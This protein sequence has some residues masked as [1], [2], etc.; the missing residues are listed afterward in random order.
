[1][2]LSISPNKGPLT[3]TFISSAAC[4]NEWMVHL[5]DPPGGEKCPSI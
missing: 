1:M 3:L 5:E 2:M 4:K